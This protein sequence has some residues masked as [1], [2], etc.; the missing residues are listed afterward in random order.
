MSGDV[1][2]R[3]INSWTLQFYPTPPVSTL[4]LII[5]TINAT[6]TEL[7]LFS[8]FHF[9]FLSHSTE[10]FTNF[11]IPILSLFQHEVK[12]VFIMAQKEIM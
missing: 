7:Y 6:K 3:A 12:I 4:W 8:S 2:S 9:V 5:S 11:S 10:V 1:T